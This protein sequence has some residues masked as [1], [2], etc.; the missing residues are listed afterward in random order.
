MYGLIGKRLSYSLSKVIHETIRPMD[1]KLIETEDLLTTLNHN[2]FKGIN[3]T[4]P[5]KKSILAFADHLDDSVKKTGVANTLIHKNGLN[6][7]YN[8]DFD[9][10]KSLID[11]FIPKKSICAII[12]NGAT[13]QSYQAALA[14][15][16]HKTLVFARNPQPHEHTLQSLCHHPEINVL[17]NTT[18]VGTS[19]DFSDTINVPF[20]QLT[21][22]NMVIDV[23]YNPF[24]TQLLLN[25]EK[26]AIKTL[27]GL[28]MLIRQ[29]IKS[30]ALFFNTSYHNDIEQTLHKSTLKK[31]LNIVFIG[32]PFSGKSHYGKIMGNRLNMSFIDLDTV[33][34]KTYNTRISEYF[35]QYGEQAFRTAEKELAI[36]SAQSMHTIISPGGGVVLNPEIMERFKQNS[37]IVY[38]DIDNQLMDQINYHSRPLV[39]NPTELK[40]LKA[41]RHELYL[42]YADIVIHKTHLDASK[43]IE[44][45]E[46][47][48]DDYLNY[49]WSLF[50]SLR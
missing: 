24:K 9:A 36:T 28:P 25:A 30:N 37:L 2:P 42:K 29:A 14:E 40:H 27:N 43:I 49:Q 4:N 7:A 23:I 16:S 32:L 17:I 18:P 3:I 8:T 34:E 47:K 46:V 35:S 33:F 13:S 26:L 10:I 20:K 1:Y 21:S 6:F 39:K 41:Q 15:T 5:Y 50:K 44:E 38:I 45:I 19:P 22:L 12:G 11:E 31:L 48:I